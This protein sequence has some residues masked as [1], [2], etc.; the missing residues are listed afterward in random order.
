MPPSRPLYVLTSPEK[1]LSVTTCSYETHLKS[2]QWKTKYRLPFY[3]MWGM[4]TGYS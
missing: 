2:Y 1:N 3:V 4:A